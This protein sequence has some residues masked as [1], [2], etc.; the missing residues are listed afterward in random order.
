M[1]AGI[2]AS[3]ARCAGLR[4]RRREDRL[5]PRPPQPVRV[6]CRLEFAMPADGY[7]DPAYFDPAYFDMADEWV[8]IFGQEDIRA[9]QPITC[10]YG[11]RGNTPIDRVARA[12]TLKLALDNSE[13]NSGRKLGYYS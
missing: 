5:M 10:E 9:Q 3:C 4:R 1:V 7:F 11:I 13:F 2:V 12:G 6:Q 8:D